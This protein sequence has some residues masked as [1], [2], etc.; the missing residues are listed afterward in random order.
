MLPK[1]EFWR[2]Y[3]DPLREKI[4]EFYLLWGILYVKQN[5]IVVLRKA[6]SYLVD[7]FRM[8]KNQ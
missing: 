4:N 5:I 2:D 1:S 3:G 7:I 8:I 6:N